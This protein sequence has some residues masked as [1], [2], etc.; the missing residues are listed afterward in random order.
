MVQVVHQVLVVQ[1]A[2]QE[3]VV[4]QV[5]RVQM[6]Q[7]EHQEQVEHQVQV[8][9]QEYHLIGLEDGITVHHMV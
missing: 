7:V 9:H 1:V 3:Q 5:H 8:V 2:H 6:V 4:C